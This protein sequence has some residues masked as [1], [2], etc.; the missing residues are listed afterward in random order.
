[1]EFEQSSLLFIIAMH[2]QIMFMKDYFAGVIDAMNE[3]VRID[4]SEHHF[5]IYD[6]KGVYFWVIF[7]F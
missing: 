3:D 7:Q 2:F 1:M 6:R 5:L 4:I